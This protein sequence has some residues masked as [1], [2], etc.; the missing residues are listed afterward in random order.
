MEFTDFYKRVKVFGTGEK[1]TWELYN[2]KGEKQQYHSGEKDYLDNDL[3]NSDVSIPA[4]TR[5]LIIAPKII[6]NNSFKNSHEYYRIICWYRNVFRD[7]YIHQYAFVD[8][9][10]SARVNSSDLEYL[11]NFEVI[12][13]FINDIKLDLHIYNALLVDSPSYNNSIV[14][15]IKLDI[16]TRL[17]TY[18]NL[19]KGPSATIFEERLASRLNTISSNN[20]FEI[21]YS[22]IYTTT[23][24][25]V[26]NLA[27]Y[28]SPPKEV[29]VFT[30]AYNS[31]VSNYI[32]ENSN[33]FGGL[34]EGLGGDTGDVKDI[35]TL[36]DIFQAIKNEIN[37]L[38][39]VMENELI[40]E[41]PDII[42]SSSYLFFKGLSENSANATTS[43][44]LS[45]KAWDKNHRINLLQRAEYVATDHSMG[46]IDSSHV[47]SVLVHEYNV[48]DIIPQTN[49][50]HISPRSSLISDSDSDFLS[51]AIQEYLRNGKTV[52]ELISEHENTNNFGDI[53]SALL[54]RES[55]VS[56]MYITKYFDKIDE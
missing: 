20:P 35:L 36:P 40:N 44:G 39:S 25:Y 30:A 11:T 12:E 15:G 7:G 3:S 45:T 5:V 13:S 53:L 51:E 27:K 26:S 46:Y 21:N 17:N 41:H 6:S 4:G 33:S 38:V 29:I 43:I 1:K 8:H 49:D 48:G 54:L 56:M 22:N 42:S 28:H 9:T 23:N 31:I 16:E 47:F 14:L 52:F 24:A 50:T 19:L 37:N 55:R 2:A 32:N 10:P 18:I 34:L